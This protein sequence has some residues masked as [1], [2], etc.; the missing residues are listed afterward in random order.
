MS[1]LSASNEIV[2][3]KE[4]IFIKSSNEMYLGNSSNGQTNKAAE[5]LYV[6]STRSV[7]RE[8]SHCFIND[9]ETEGGFSHRLDKYKDWKTLK[10]TTNTQH[11]VK[12][13]EGS[14]KSGDRINFASE[15]KDHISFERVSEIKVD[16]VDKINSSP[17]VVYSKKEHS[18]ENNSSK[19]DSDKLVDKKTT[20]KSKLATPVDPKKVLKK[21]LEKKNSYSEKIKKENSS[22]IEEKKN[23]S[24]ELKE[25]LGDIDGKKGKTDRKHYSEGGPQAFGLSNGF[26]ART[27]SA[28]DNPNNMYNNNQRYHNVE[29]SNKL[30]YSSKSS[31]KVKNS[32]TVREEHPILDEK[33]KRERQFAYEQ[34]LKQSFPVT[35]RPKTEGKQSGIV[36]QK[37]NFFIPTLIKDKTVEIKKRRVSDKEV[38]DLSESTILSNRKKLLEDFELN[39]LK[40]REKEKNKESSQNN[41]KISKK[42]KCLNEK[43]RL[44]KILNEN[45]MELANEEENYENDKFEEEKGDK[46]KNY[47]SNSNQDQELSEGQ[48]NPGLHLRN[49]SSSYPNSNSRTKQLV[50]NRNYSDGSTYTNRLKTSEKS[51]PQQAKK[52]KIDSFDFIKKI[53]KNVINEDEIAEM[54]NELENSFRKSFN[55][56]IQKI[57][58]PEQRRKKSYDEVINNNKQIKVDNRTYQVYDE[59]NN[60]V[61]S[62]RQ[63]SSNT[64]RNELKNYIKE[65]KK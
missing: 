40:T 7:G 52:P 27:K 8:D 4:N 10:N 17:S 25:N 22:R 59:E 31:E 63:K 38:P 28:S 30:G 2:N 62:Y 55:I 18:I 14:I 6:K 57:N 5:V 64:D 58:H 46:S 1:N 16:K 21:Q 43:G 15:E 65:S 32:N 54:G 35:Q 56:K 60:F 53:G 13:S 3:S 23:S 36:V 41:D 33:Q 29:E 20:L 39:L 11:K 34:Y 37:N 26:H 45:D 50:H 51:I 42:L 44:E 9:I 49:E 61:F 19:K 24:K 12:K 47:D 48:S